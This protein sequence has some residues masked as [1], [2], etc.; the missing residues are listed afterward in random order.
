MSGQRAEVSWHNNPITQHQHS[1]QL[2]QRMSQGEER[3]DI[4][5]K[6]SGIIRET[7]LE[8]VEDRL[9]GGIFG[10]GCSDIRPADHM[11]DKGCSTQ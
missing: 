11:F 7:F 10:G 8:Y 4:I 9:D 6:W 5:R 1:I 3:A 2:I